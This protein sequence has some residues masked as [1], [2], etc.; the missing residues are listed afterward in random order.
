MRERDRVCGGVGEREDVCVWEERVCGCVCVGGER[1]CLSPGG[2]GALG[3][4]GGR[5]H[6]L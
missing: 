6:S 5:I 3:Y 1:V 2:G 4:L